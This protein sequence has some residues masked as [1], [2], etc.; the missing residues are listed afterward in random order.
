MSVTETASKNLNAISVKSSVGCFLNF[1]IGVKGAVPA[2]AFSS[3]DSKNVG[4]Q[5]LDSNC[6]QFGPFP[7]SKYSWRLFA[8]NTSAVQAPDVTATDSRET[9]E[10]E[11]SWLGASTYSLQVDLIDASGTSTNVKNLSLT[12][13][14]A[15]DTYAV[16]LDVT[17][18]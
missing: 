14:L 17:W 10:L 13:L 15:T 2:F 4:H 3:V 8:K 11:F 9:Y 12:S 5:L 1:R 16:S 6:P 18:N 7:Q